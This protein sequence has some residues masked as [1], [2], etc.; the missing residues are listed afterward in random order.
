M[1]LKKVVLPAP[2]GPMMLKIRPRSMS[3]VMLLTAVRPPKR[4]RR[5]G[6]ERMILSS[7]TLGS[8]LF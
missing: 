1:A 4:F 2:L 8:F 7:D 6:V 3:T 5:C